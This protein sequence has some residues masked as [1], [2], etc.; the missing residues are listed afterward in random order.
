MKE[1]TRLLFHMQH[2]RGLGN[3]GTK[4]LLSQL[5]DP[6]KIYN[7]PLSSIMRLSG[8]TALHAELFY[9]D[10]HTFNID[11]YQE[12]YQQHDIHWISIY[13]ENYPDLLKNVYDPPFIL[14]MKGRRELLEF[15]TKLAVVGSRQATSYTCDNLRILMPGL[16][17]KNVVIISGLARGA[18]TMAHKSAI[19]AGAPTIG[20][21]AG[22]FHHIYPRENIQLAEYMMKEQLLISEYPPDT[23]PQKWH[24][25][26]RNRI[27]SG[28]S[29]AI[30]VTEAQKKSGTFITAD[31]ALNEGRDILCIPGSV[32]QKLSEGTNTLIKEGAKMVLSIEDIFFELDV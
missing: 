23:K 28:L 10:F 29:Q 26:F 2:C 32:N 14:F 15:Q 1:I 19:R 13:D 27:I 31:Y 17:E 11:Y 18:D 30:L 6:M 16:A 5:S 4:R 12:Y 25:P 9:S 22:G 21:I 24:F 8:S 7:L 3:K 20:V